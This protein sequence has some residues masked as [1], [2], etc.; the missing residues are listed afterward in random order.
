MRIDRKRD[1]KESNR[2]RIDKA[3]ESEALVGM[4]DSKDCIIQS[5]IERKR[6]ISILDR[7]E[8]KEREQFD[9]ESSLE[10]SQTLTLGKNIG[11]R[12]LT[13]ALCT[14]SRG[15]AAWEGH[16]SRRFAGR[17]PLSRGTESRATVAWNRGHAQARAQERNQ[18][19]N[20]KR[21][22]NIEP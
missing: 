12:D 4:E 6:K 14:P 3:N 7:K 18:Y 10:C 20:R 9:H 21:K 2:S 8:T 1:K 19:S 16:E 17:P 22:A 13:V 15:T 11:R 5:R